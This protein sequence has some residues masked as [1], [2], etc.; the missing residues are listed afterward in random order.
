MQHATRLVIFDLFGTLVKYGVMH[1]PFR[2]IMHWARQQGRQPREDDARKLMTIDAD[3]QGLFLSIGINPPAELLEK[4][5]HDIRDEIDSLQLFDDVNRTLN[6]LA[7]YDI[8]IA[9]C[10]NLAKP[11]G[12]A[13]PR[14]LSSIEVETYLSYEVGYIKPDRQIYELITSKSHLKPE[15]CLFIGDTL[16]ADY[17]GPK[18]FGF[19]ARHLV[20][21]KPLSHTGQIATLEDLVFSKSV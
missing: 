6:R 17:E 12:D 10:S 11:Y 8:P 3:L 13:I 5:E 15:H 16:L 18:L 21:D 20:R 19:Q 1:H 4:L 7:E 2:K 14:L 9:I